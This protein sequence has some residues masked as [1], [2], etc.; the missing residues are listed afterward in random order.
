MGRSGIKPGLAHLSGL[1]CAAAGTGIQ[2]VSY[3]HLE[4]GIVY[5]DF[6]PFLPVVFSQLTEGL[7]D[8]DDLQAAASRS[9]EHHLGAFYL[10][11]G[12]VLIAKEDTTVLELAAVF[13]RNRQDFPVQLLDE[14]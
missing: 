4:L 7:D 5:N 3:T 6:R 1:L 11:E 2:A 13:V 9:T 12:A 8:R 10:W 14:Q